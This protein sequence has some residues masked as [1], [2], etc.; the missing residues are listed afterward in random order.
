MKTAND[1][2]YFSLII[3]KR[4]W[5]P[6]LIVIALLSSLVLLATLQYRWLGQISD[7]DRERMHKR[8][9]TDTIRFAEDFNR[10]IQTAY[11]NFQISSADWKARNWNEF[12]RRFSFWRQ[13][14][15]HPDLIG[16]FYYVETENAENPLRY[17]KEKGEFETSAWT[18]ELAELKQVL[19][20]PDKNF[21]SV[22][23]EI[24]ALLMPIR[25]D[26]KVVD[27]IFIRKNAVTEARA[28]PESLAKNFEMP[29]K[30]GV[31]VIR[32]DGDVI[33]NQILSELAK[34][35]FSEGSGESNYRLAVVN[36][37]KETIFQTGGAGGVNSADAGAPLFDL[38]P[39]NFL[40]LTSRLPAAA[41]TANI[42]RR[43][44]IPKV[45][46]GGG[47]QQ[48]EQTMVFTTVEKKES[49]ETFALSPGDSN[50]G[51]QQTE[52]NIDT[53]AGEKN[54]QHSPVMTP[55]LRVF[56]RRSAAGDVGKWTLNVQ[57]TA[58][59]LEQFIANTR[60]K[61]LAISFGIL[62]LLGVSVVLIFLSAQ[63]AKRLAQK[64]IDFVSSVSH[65]FRT[66]L[67]V[68][69]SA[70]ENLTDGVV[71]NE[72]QVS[73]YGKLITREGKKLSAMV[74]QILEFAG[75][76]SGKRKYDFRETNAERILAKA[77]AE[78]Q[79]LIDEKG[80]VLETEIAANLPG[81]SA[82]EN[83]LSQ[84]IQNLIGNGLKYS[85]GSKWLKIMAS[86]GGGSLKIAVEDK[87]IGIAPKD[88]AHIFE[89]FYR[90][91]AVVDEQIHGNGLGLSL[92]KQIVEAHKGKIKVKSEP[93]KGSRF[94]IELPGKFRAANGE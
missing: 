20:T 35:Y 21:D 22:D 18:N 59:S 80:F 16:D 44:A 94:T 47:D 36:Q 87:G 43:E 9:E 56:D 68:I 58:G 19:T 30:I 54:D 29:K 23:A 55:R 41:G 52:I 64:Q 81:I 32:L 3:M 57:H 14:N 1:C 83:A 78:C 45:E 25:E 15:E 86:N 7:G 92:V 88:A 46:S 65:E 10:E 71:R 79:P 27:T 49:R 12:N 4:S 11:L 73:Q 75:A 34:K 2:L 6:I 90:A 42:V 93:G 66:P 40:L 17:N 62:S 53:N 26:E 33:K 74:E 84:A 77:V 13:N 8:L 5:F 69:Y 37:A 50:E 61:N 48:R 38:S 67:A 85:N 51:K 72:G 24:P 60:R 89:P 82:D 70:G 76:R 28:T 91:K 31:L 39:D 63:R